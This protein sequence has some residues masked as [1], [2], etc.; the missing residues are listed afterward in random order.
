MTGFTS[1]SFVL[2][3]FFISSS[4]FLVAQNSLSTEGFG[5]KWVNIND[6]DV[7][8]SQITI[9]ALVRRQNNSNM[10]IVSKHDG[11]ADCNYLFRPNSF[12]ISITDGFQFVLN[13]ITLPNNTWYHLAATYDATTLTFD[14][15][16]QTYAATV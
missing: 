9:E 7:S 3:L 12:Q 8:G 13:P 16:Q 2:V 6:L 14:T 15:T 5:Q 11:T 10:N 1:R 4:F